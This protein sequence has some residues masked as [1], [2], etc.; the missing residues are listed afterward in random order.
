MADDIVSAYRVLGRVQGVGYRWW[1]R[2]EA[3]ALGLSGNVRN[4]ADGSVTVVVRGPEE[5]VS[6]LRER[7][8]KGPPFARVLSVAP[9]DAP[10]D[11]RRL[12]ADVFE[13]LH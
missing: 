7:L 6:T 1:A 3:T 11:R 9:F 10:D 13:I 4:E 12:E 2:T 8:A 5:A